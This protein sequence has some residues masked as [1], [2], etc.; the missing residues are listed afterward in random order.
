VIQYLLTIDPGIPCKNKPDICL[1][2]RKDSYMQ[3]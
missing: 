2:I 1:I 3:Q